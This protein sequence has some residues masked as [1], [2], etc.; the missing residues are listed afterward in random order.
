MLRLKLPRGSKHGILYRSHLSDLEFLND[1]L[2]E[3]Y[4]RS[5]KIP[6]L[7]VIQTCDQESSENKKSNKSHCLTAKASLIEFYTNT[8]LAKS[9]EDL[10]VN[11]WHHG[12]IKKILQNGLLVELPYSLDGFCAN[13]EVKYL[14]ELKATNINGLGV[15]QSVL[16]RINKLFND[17][18]RFITNVR[19]RHDLMQKNSKD[20]EYMMQIFKSFIINT[21][22]V[23]DFY[24]N[25]P[26]G[27]KGTLFENLISKARIGSIVKVAVKSLSLG[28][29]KIEC[30]LIDE[31]VANNF[32]TSSSILGNAYVD[33]SSDQEN[34]LHSKTYKIGAKFNAMILGFDPLARVFCLT[35][36]KKKIKTYAKN[37]D[38]NF[39]SQLTCKD[40]QTVKAD[41]LYVS[42]WFCIVGLKAHALGRLAIMPLFRNDFTQ[43]NTFRVKIEFF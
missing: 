22:Q 20:S 19:T 33:V 18:Q 1:V 15:G 7:M 31:L 41:I 3:F 17:K 24:S 13:Q 23:F 43:L 26:I 42:Q 5:L 30:M 10:R 12:W 35:L 34:K 40:E 29:G 8:Q 14:K 11:T 25:S 2:F 4:K 27:E 16:V 37:F 32:N 28:S 39:R 36:D 21:K 38:Q 6:N 9:F